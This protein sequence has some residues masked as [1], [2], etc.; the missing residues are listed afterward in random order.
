MDNAE[1]LI[2]FIFTPISTIYSTPSENNPPEWSDHIQIIG[3]NHPADTRY[4]HPGKFIADPMCASI[5]VF[6]IFYIPRMPDPP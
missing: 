1:R 4:R 3:R 6:S 2:D 5:A